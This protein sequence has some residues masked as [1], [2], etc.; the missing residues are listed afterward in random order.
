MIF[1]LLLFEATFT[2]FLKIK[3]YKEVTEQEEW[4][5]CLLFLLDDGKIRSRI[6]TPEPDPYLILTDPVQDPGGP[7][8][9][10]PTG[11]DPDPQ[12]CQ[13]DDIFLWSPSSNTTT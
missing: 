13:T 3:S 4:R 8:N 10:D 2:S 9:M 1:C 5:F 12:H 11:P 7:K 6:Q